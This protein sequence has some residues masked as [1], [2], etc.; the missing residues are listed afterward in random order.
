M[1][2]LLGIVH[3]SVASLL[4]AAHCIFFLRGL[5][6]EARMFE[7]GKIDRLARSL[8]QALLPAAALSG[9]IVL[10]SGAPVSLSA[11]LFVGFAPLLAIPLVFFGRILVKRK[12]QA[13]WLLPALNLILI[14]TAF[15]TGLRLWR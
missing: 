3:L 11:H 4:L 14:V 9:V 8:A 7:P 15:V 2:P 6:I 12:T 13:P 10:A 1:R 5:Y